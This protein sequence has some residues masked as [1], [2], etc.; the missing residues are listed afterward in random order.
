MYTFFSSWFENVNGLWHIFSY[1]TARCGASLLLSFA[2]MLICMPKYIAF[3]HKWQK[4]GQPIRGN[5]LPEHLQKVGTPTMGGVMIIIS[6][7][8]SC[9]LFGNLKNCYMAIL[10]LSLLAF[11]IAGFLD[12]YRKI[13]KKNVAGMSAKMKFVLQTIIAVAVV[14]LA[15]YV[16]DIDDYGNTLTFPFFR[17]IVFNIGVFYTIFRVLVIVGASNA[18]NL[19]DGLD[20]LVSV[21][22]ILTASVFLVF[23]YVISNFQM[24]QYLLFN[25]QDGAQEVCVFLSALIGACIGFLWFNIKPAQIFMGDTGSLAL[26]GVLGSSA[27]L[28]KSEFLLAIAGGLFVVETLSVILQVGYFKATKGKR[29][30]KMTPIH[31][32][33]EK[34]G[35]SEMQVVVRFWIISFFFAIIALSSLKVR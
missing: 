15:N 35:W 33:F 26:G 21:P 17:K 22:I 13:K 5:Y 30:F 8:V 2:I 34:T 4:K 19:T 18:I 31:H 20:G 6:I 24:S 9:V 27:V 32:H 10:I 12:D 7:L 29:L 14:L 25:Y 11:G 23:G 1:I 16:I 3:S 28:I